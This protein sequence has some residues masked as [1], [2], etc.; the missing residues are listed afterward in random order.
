MSIYAAAQEG[1]MENISEYESAKLERDAV[2]EI[3]DTVTYQDNDGYRISY[4]VTNTGN[5]V[6]TDEDTFRVIFSGPYGMAWDYTEEECDFA[7]V[8]L[9]GIGVGESKTFD[10]VLDVKPEMLDKYGFIDLS[11]IHIWSSSIRMQR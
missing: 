9:E 3:S 7:T 5:T 2:Y 8:S 10:E 11:L 6:S 4:T 1:G